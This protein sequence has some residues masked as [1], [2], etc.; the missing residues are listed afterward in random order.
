MAYV[1]VVG[2]IL[3]SSWIIIVYIVYNL[4]MLSVT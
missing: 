3:F 4:V 2:I 1:V